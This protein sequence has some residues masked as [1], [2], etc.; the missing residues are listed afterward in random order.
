[1]TYQLLENYF[2][3]LRNKNKTSFKLAVKNGKINGNECGRWSKM[4]WDEL[5]KNGVSPLDE[6]EFGESMYYAISRTIDCETG[7]TF[8]PKIRGKKNPKD[9]GLAQINSY[10]WPDVSDEEAFNPR[11][12]IKFIVEWFYKDYPFYWKCYGK[13]KEEYQEVD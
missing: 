1:M 4:L 8:D 6:W 2:K 13:T 7:G 10:W 9:R 5:I 11:F 3:N 12:S